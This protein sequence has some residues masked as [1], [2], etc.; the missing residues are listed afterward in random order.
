MSMNQNEEARAQHAVI[1]I[2]NAEGEF[3]PTTDPRTEWFD[4]AGLGLF[5]HF[6]I[7]AVF[8]NCDLSWGMVQ[9]WPWGKPVST[10]EKPTPRQ[11]YEIGPRDFTAENYDPEPWLRKAVEAGFKYA[12]LTTKHHDGYTLWPSKYSEYG[13]QHSLQGRDLV[14]P[15]VNA[16]LKLGLKV[17]LY[18]SAPDWAFNHEY[19]NFTAEKGKYLDIDLNERGPIE[20]MPEEHAKAYAEKVRGEVFDLLDRYHVDVLWF[21]G[22][23]EFP[24]GYP[25]PFTVEE[26][27][28]KQPWMLINPRFFKGGDFKTPECAF[29][30][31]PIE[32]RWEYCDQLNNCGW[33]Y[34]VHPYKTVGWFTEKLCKTRA[35]GGNFLANV[36]PDAAG[37]LPNDY[38]LR[39]RDIRTWMEAHREALFDGIEPGMKEER[40]NT[41][42]TKRGSEG[43]WY[44]HILP[45]EGLKEITITDCKTAP[46]ECT[47]LSN[48]QSVEYTY[49]DG[50]MTISTEGLSSDCVEI[51]KIEW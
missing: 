15:F 39:M 25:D 12:V 31:E 16:C 10:I 3:Q 14:G 48:G 27:R 4:E 43:I 5:V 35:W 37:Q 51:I 23:G 20:P 49:F 7:S 33:G 1:G 2:Q 21:D 30:A 29:P 32:G 44:A 17:G 40:I 38:Y 8:G 46:R 41:W 34:T 24:E 42:L 36:G 6:G 19:R 11:Y 28:A 18:Y 50:T 47:L 13:V 45:S 26:L 9:K 22:H